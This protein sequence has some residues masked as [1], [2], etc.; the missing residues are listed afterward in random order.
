[1]LNQTI[2]RRFTPF[3]LRA[4]DEKAR[5]VGVS[6]SSESREVLRYDWDSN[7]YVPEILSHVDGACDLSPFVAAGSVLRNHDPNQI[8]GVPVEASID[9][10]G[11]RGRALIRFGTTP[12]AEQAFQDVRQGILRGVSVGYE[13][14]ASES[15]KPGAKSNAGHEGPCVVAT[16]WRVHEVSFTPVPADSG[17]GV[18]R[19]TATAQAGKED[20][21]TTRKRKI[22][23]RNTPANPADVAVTSGQRADDE[24]GKCP[25]CGAECAAGCEKCPEC[26]AE[27]A[28]GCEKCPEC[29]AECAAECEKRPECGAAEGKKNAKPTQRA[30]LEERDRCVAIRAMIKIAK[31]PAEIGDQMIEDGTE[32]AAARTEIEDQAEQRDRLPLSR[33]GGVESGEDR[34]DKLSRF[35]RVNLARRVGLDADGEDAKVEPGHVRLLDV[36]RAWLETIGVPGVRFMAPAAIAQELFNPRNQFRAG[37]ANASGDVANLLANVQNKALLKSYRSTRATWK[38]WCKKGSLADF[39]ASKRV[40]LSDFGQFKETGENGEISDSKISDRGESL[41]LATYGRAISLTLQMIINDD[42]DA[43]SKLPA[44]IGASAASLPSRLVYT[45]MMSNA[46]VG[47]TMGDAIALFDAATHKNYQ[48]GAGYALDATYYKV[49]MAKALA[50][51]R[52]MTSFAPA[53]ENEFAT[54]PVDI[55]PAILLVPPGDPEYYAQPLVNPNLYVVADNAMFKGKYQ[56]VVEPRLSHSGYSGYSA[57]AWYLIGDPA[58]ADTCEVAFL[59]GNELPSTMTWEDFDRLAFRY[60]AWLGCAVQALDWRG[61]VKMTGA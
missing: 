22:I 9:T 34:R 60:R 10:D 40:Q 61:I 8:I 47:P 14:L 21:M 6:F 48:T 38:S 1:M 23:H 54:E 5:T 46:G 50:L 59:D 16:K 33:P 24:S 29:G 41:Q 27:C 53:G 30:R 42:L 51:F 57:T 35:L 15:V 37:A 32:V 44:M 43:L 18:G 13:V 28:A 3:E 52:Q 56:V 58:V 17:V 12:T 26:G 55:E 4:V 7:A 2:Q 11:R 45:H 20:T 49:G 31:L 39:K 36:G 19:S 25:E